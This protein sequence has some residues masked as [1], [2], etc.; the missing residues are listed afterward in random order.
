MA[1]LIIIVLVLILVRLLQYSPLRS[2]DGGTGTSTR[3]HLL[4]LREGDFLLLV[5]GPFWS[6]YFAS[7]QRSLLPLGS[8]DY[9][10]EFR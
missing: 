8:V 1:A 7:G 10:G 9:G 3:D 5:K 6:V 4:N 2:S